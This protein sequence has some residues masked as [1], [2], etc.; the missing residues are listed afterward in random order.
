[1]KILLVG[2]GSLGPVT[3]LIATSRALRNLRK[4]IEFV[5]I[6]TPTGPERALAEAEGMK[7]YALPVVKL[8]R[9]PT[10]KW[11]T[12][13]FDWLSVRRL[14][15]QL[16]KELKPDAV[17]SVG[18]FT[19]T[20]VII[21]AAHLGIP[22]AMH[23]LDLRPGLS[24][25]KVARLCSSVTTSFEY[26]RPP[27]GEWVSDERIASPVRFSLDDLPTRSAAAK[28]FKLDAKKPVVLI[29]GGGTG[30]RAL[31]QFAA[32]N[33]AALLECTQVIHL[34]GR[35]K[36]EGLKDQPGYVVRELLVDDMVMAYALADVS[37]SRAGFASLAEA[38]ASLQIP[39]IAVPLPGTEQEDNA[40]AFEEQ[41]ALIVI[42]EARP[43]FDEE[44][45][46]ALKLLLK[47]KEGRVRM[48]KQAN[49]FL[50]TDNGTALAKRVLRM[51]KQKA[52]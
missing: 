38:A 39:T 40:R 51:L 18:G 52:N 44:I 34:T 46:S 11:L 22:S 13:P 3:P 31:N 5:W 41:G 10:L 12:L 25:R 37:I 6:G 20:P 45:L 49:K 36:L 26:Q 43:Q 19:A 35:G 1:M 24:N 23:Q 32:R 42:E 48:G 27:F 21:E 50:P 14:A 9:Y 8:H 2:G 30:A 16:L 15:K 17:V 33:R 29:V 47:D 28:H 7:F 4:D